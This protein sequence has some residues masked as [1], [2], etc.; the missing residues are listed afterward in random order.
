MKS[1]HR[2]NGETILAIPSKTIQVRSMAS[3]ICNVYI[4]NALDK[5]LL[6]ICHNFGLP[7]YARQ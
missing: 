4:Y 7:Y 6:N 2:G 5:I 1:E 3:Q